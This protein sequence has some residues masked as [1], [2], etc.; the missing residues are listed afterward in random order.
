[1]PVQPEVLMRKQPFNAS[2]P[3]VVFPAVHDAGSNVDADAF[4]AHPA[5][6][7]KPKLCMLKKDSRAAGRGG[8][9]GANLPLRYFRNVHRIC[10]ALLS[11]HRELRTTH[12][13]LLF[14][15]EAQENLAC[16]LYTPEVKNNIY[17]I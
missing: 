17:K 11:E 9:P 3:Q 14:F 7:N 15:Y 10:S 8:I 16:E 6:D 1:M 5:T 4:V 13:L 12:D 2:Q